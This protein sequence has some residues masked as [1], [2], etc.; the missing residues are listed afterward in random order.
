MFQHF[1]EVFETVPQTPGMLSNRNSN[2][3]ITTTASSSNAASPRSMSAEG[4][5]EA[6]F[7][8][9]LWSGA[10][11]SVAEH[12]FVCPSKMCKSCRQ[13]V[14]AQVINQRLQQELLERET[15]QM[16]GSKKT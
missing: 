15:Q 4:K 13:G 16:Y 11:R 6:S 2:Q 12:C 7:E 9:C 5:Q 3:Q 1:S 10:K 14:E 8:I